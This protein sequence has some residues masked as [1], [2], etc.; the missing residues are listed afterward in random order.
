MVRFV[1][2]EIGRVDVPE[3]SRPELEK[4][5]FGLYEDPVLHRLGQP[6]KIE[7]SIRMAFGSTSA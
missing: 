7:D 3:K 4:Y 6:N 1:D 2:L 5:L